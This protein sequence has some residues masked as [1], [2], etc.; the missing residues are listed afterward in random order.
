MCLAG[1]ALPENRTAFFSWDARTSPT[2]R[3]SCPARSP[4]GMSFAVQ[5]AQRPGFDTWLSHVDD[6]KGDAVVLGDVDVGPREEQPTPSDVSTRIPPC[7]LPESRMASA[8]ISNR[9]PGCAKAALRPARV[10]RAGRT[11]ARV[12]ALGVNPRVC[13]DGRL[14]ERRR[15]DEDGRHDEYKERQEEKR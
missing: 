8:V 14:Y 12:I 5:L 1:T 7:R 13:L 2:S 11:I 3:S 6:E 15:V 10:R 4:D 9:M